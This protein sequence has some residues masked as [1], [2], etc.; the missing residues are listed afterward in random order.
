MERKGAP[1]VVGMRKKKKRTKSIDLPQHSFWFKRKRLHYFG[2]GRVFLSS[3][4]TGMDSVGEEE[5][6]SL[7]Y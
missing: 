4:M 3:C 6:F 5:A 2:R 7:F 1:P